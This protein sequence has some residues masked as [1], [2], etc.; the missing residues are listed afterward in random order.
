MYR[1]HFRTPHPLNFLFRY[2]ILKPLQLLFVSSP[3][4]NQKD[5][6][7]VAHS[8]MFLPHNS[9]LEKSLL[10]NETDFSSDK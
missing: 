10:H 2:R 5:P 3:K 6:P 1:V 8:L 9:Q 4:S 7:Q